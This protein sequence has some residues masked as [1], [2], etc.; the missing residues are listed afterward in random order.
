MLGHYVSHMSVICQRSGSKVSADYRLIDYSNRV[1]PAYQSRVNQVLANIAAD[2]L[3]DS[4]PG[5]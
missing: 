5:C 1:S 4:Q 3:I 2:M